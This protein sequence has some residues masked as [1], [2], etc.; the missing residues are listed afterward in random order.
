MTTSP[1][2]YP[3]PA[4]S[5]VPAASRASW[6]RARKTGLGASDTAAVLGLSPWSTPLSV[7]I[8][9][10]RDEVTSLETEAAEWG[11]AHE[12]TI[13][14]RVNHRWRDRIGTVKPTPGLLRHDDY[15]WLLATPDRVLVKKGKVTGL[16][17]IKTAGHRQRHAW[18]NGVPV[19]Y[20]I[21][22]QQQLAVTGLDV[23]WLAVLHGGNHMPD[24]YRIDRDDAAIQQIVDY[25]GRWWKEHV[26]GDVP[27]D[28][29]WPADDDLLADAYLSAPGLKET[30]DDEVRALITQLRNAKANTK[31]AKA[32]EDR[33][34]F[35]VKTRLQEAEAFVDAGGLDLVTWKPY[36]KRDF[37][38]NRF[39]ADHPELAAKYVRETTVRPLR[40][41]GE[42]NA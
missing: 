12:A 3:T 37:D 22:V 1:P 28:P 30:A 38:V 18:D 32:E 13:A 41:K 17:E 8:D 21:Q 4:G 2:L 29:T 23:A 26:E 11:L 27:P 36:T 20:Q 9:K 16:L 39:R 31:A 40:M 10:R 15:P 19:Y 33:I 25:T 7:W 24:P 5:V 35:E 6:L 42:R 14:R 34:A